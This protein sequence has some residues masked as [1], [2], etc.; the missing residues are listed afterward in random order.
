M[1]LSDQVRV[2]VRRVYF[3]GN[4]R[5]TKSQ[6]YPAVQPFLNRPLNANELGRLTAAV[7]DKYRQ[8][9]WIVEVYIPQ[10][11]LDQNELNLQVVE[12][13]RNSGKPGR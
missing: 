12:D 7:T 13:V 6:L 10:Q 8:A 4:S 1:V 2:N 11:A 5:L 3:Q 9:G